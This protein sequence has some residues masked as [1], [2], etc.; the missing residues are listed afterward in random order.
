M[1]RWGQVAAA[2]FLAA[3]L[4]VLGIW[5]LSWGVKMAVEKTG[6]SIV[7]A[8]V[9]LDQAR[10]NLWTLSARLNRLQ[11]T[12]PEE[13]MTNALEVGSLRLHLRLKPLFWKRFVIEEAAL[14]GLRFNTPR[15]TSGA[16][17]HPN[18]TPSKPSWVGEQAQAVGEAAVE[19]VKQ[20]FDPDRWVSED[21]LASLKKVRAEQERL[22]QLYGDWQSRLNTLDVAALKTEGETL[23]A[24]LKAYKP[25]G[26]EGLKTGAELA[27]RVKGFEKKATGVVNTAQDLKKDLQ[28]QVRQTRQSLKEIDRLRKEDIRRLVDKAKGELSLGS[29]SSAL[30]GDTWAERLKIGLSWAKKAKALAAAS[31]G[32]PPPTPSKRQGVDIPFPLRQSFPRFHLV[33]A[34]LSGE[35]PGEL[36]FT[37]TLSD[38]SSDPALVGRPTVLILQ[39]EKAPRRAS[40]KFQGNFAR[41]PSVLTL[42][43]QASGWPVSGRKLA[44]VKGRALTLAGGTARADLKATLTGDILRGQGEATVADLAFAPLAQ[45]PADRWIQLL[46]RSLARMRELQLAGEL[47]GTTEHPSLRAKSNLDTALR[48]AAEAGLQEALAEAQGQVEKKVDALLQDKRQALDSLLKEKSAGLEKSLGLKS[49]ELDEARQKL[50]DAL[51]E[52]T[53]LS[54]G[55]ASQKIKLPDLKKLFRK[56]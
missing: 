46:D 20:H 19:N 23:L 2:L 49:G 47:G 28:D 21:Q 36:A 40:L 29:A 12:N 15:R 41:D 9:N 37:G 54:S 56:P 55:G 25:S 51:A 3:G 24:D 35:A 7:G 5:G 42:E 1:I 4:W 31:K 39:G 50:K 32:P 53:S 17:P 43:A 38:V 22:T 27:Q 16:L 26:L 13:P 11:V 52:K 6:T 44:S 34:T 33:K 45:G 30:L 10:V 48:D 18:A 8:R 14:E